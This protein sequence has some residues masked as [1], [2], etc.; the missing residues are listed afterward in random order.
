MHHELFE[1]V[2]QTPFADDY[3]IETMH[4]HAFNA[5]EAAG[6]AQEQG[7]FWEMH[8]RL[9]GSQSTLQPP[10]RQTYAI[11][12]GLNQNLFQ[13]CLASGRQALAIRR[14]MADAMQIQVRG[15]PTFVLG[16]LLQIQSR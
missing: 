16:L 9:F 11:A 14:D 15:T 2:Q 3:P 8:A 10:L 12:T 4:K 6:C 7:R 1:R 13:D 5:A